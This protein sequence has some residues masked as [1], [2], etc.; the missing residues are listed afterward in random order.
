M[1]N[2]LTP[3]RGAVPALVLIWA[4]SASAF[5]SPKE[6]RAI[7][8]TPVTEATRGGEYQGESPLGTGV[9]RS[10]GASAR[11]E[12]QASEKDPELLGISDI[13]AAIQ[14]TLAEDPEKNVIRVADY[15]KVPIANGAVSFPLSGATPPPVTS[16]DRAFL[17]RGFVTRTDGTRL[18]CWAVVQVL[19]RRKIVRT[20]VSLKAGHLLQP[21]D[22][23][24]FEAPVCPL[25]IQK[26]QELRDYVG[27]SLKRSMPALARLDRE[28]L[29]TPPIVRSG[30]RVKVEVVSGRTHLQFEAECRS[31]AQAGKSVQ[32]LNPSTGRTFKGVAREDGSVLVSVRGIN[33]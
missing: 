31:N 9:D 27:L 1:L 12:N 5:G 18:Q 20:K 14:R 7:L 4:A 28:M 24:T 33:P 6:T 17:W 32:L 29:E 2:H 16:A 19:T 15:S 22:L 3:Y 26:D 23:E 21:A 10:K 8:Q 13:E 30:D 11:L 25:V